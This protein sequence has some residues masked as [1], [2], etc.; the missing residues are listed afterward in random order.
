MRG[1]EIPK[2]AFLLSDGRTHDHPLD[3]I[4]AEKIRQTIPGLQFWAYGI[5]SSFL[6]CLKATQNPKMKWVSD[7]RALAGVHFSQLH[8]CSAPLR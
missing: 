6:Y 2:I 1:K 4:W 3:K 7:E 5:N 8:P